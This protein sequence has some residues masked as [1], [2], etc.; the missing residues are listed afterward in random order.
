MLVTNFTVGSLSL[1]LCMTGFHWSVL[2]DSF[3]MIDVDIH[4]KFKVLF[5]I[6]DQKFSSCFELWCL[7]CSTNI[8]VLIRDWLFIFLGPLFWWCWS[9]WFSLKSVSSASS[10]FPSWHFD[11][12]VSFLMFLIF[13][14]CMFSILLFGDM[15]LDFCS[16][17]S[18]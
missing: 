18:T 6:V 2:I 15:M 16:R 4:A 17:V 10:F 9:T 11:F 7:F 1:L 12:L 3:L 5:N 13:Y 14:G 8:I